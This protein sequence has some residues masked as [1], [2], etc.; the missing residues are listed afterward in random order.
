MNSRQTIDIEP[1][2]AQDLQAPTILFHDEDDICA[3]V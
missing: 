2:G 1:R 3:K